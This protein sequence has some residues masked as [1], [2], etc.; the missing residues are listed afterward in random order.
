MHHIRLS[1][2][3]VIFLHIGVAF[4][5]DETAYVINTSGETLS[6]I[7]LTAGV[8]TNDILPLGSDVLCYPNQIVVRDTLAYVVNSG[9]D[10]IQVINLTT[11]TMVDFIGTGAGSNPF[12]MAFSDDGYAYVTQMLYNGVARLDVESGTIVHEDSVGVSPEG[13]LIVGSKAYI[14]VTAFDFGSFT[15][16]QGKVVVYDLAGD[17]VTTEVDVSKNPQY[18]ALDMSGRVHVVCTGDYFSSFG[19]I[20][21]INPATDQ[22]IDDFSIGGSPGQLTIGPDDIAFL[23]AGGWVT[24]GYMYSYNAATLDLYHGAANPITVDSGC[25]MVVAYQDS[26][27]YEG[28]FSDKVVQTDTSGIELAVYALGDGPAH[29]DF[30][31]RPGD[32]NGDFSVD[33]ADLTAFIDWLFKT[34]EPPLYPFWRGDF[35]GASGPGGPFDIADLSYMVDYL[36]RGGP[37]PVVGKTWIRL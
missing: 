13:I 33:V 17:S 26:T 23:A 29:L 11:E 2:L 9:T 6:K 24:E 5:V 10:E 3:V 7:N 4:A 14:A 30:N 22:V 15:Y 21:V 19:H 36:F 37:P 18:L 35:D 28:G 34:G 32:Y 20:Y 1:L 12:W 8:V 16:G 25:A 31:Y 27:V